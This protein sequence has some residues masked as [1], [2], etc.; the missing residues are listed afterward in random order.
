MKKEWWN[1]LLPMG[2]VVRLKGADRSLMI[3]GRSQVQAGDENL[4]YDYSGVIYPEGYLSRDK[5]ALFNHEDIEEIRYVGYM[6]LIQRRFNE[7]LEAIHS[8]LKSGEVSP[9]EVREIFEEMAAEQ[10]G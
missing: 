10:E 4:I 8:G 7:L 2:S 9:D 1:G 5:I 3:V 6:D